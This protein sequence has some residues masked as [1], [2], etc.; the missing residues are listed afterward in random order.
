MTAHSKVEGWHLRLLALVYIRQ[1]TAQETQNN[2]ESTRRQDELAQ[3]ARQMGWPDT[4]VRVVDENLGTSGARSQ[5]RTGFQRLVAS[6]GMG[7]VGIVLAT[8]V[9][10]LYRLSSDWHRV[11]E[12]CAVFQLLVA[13]ED[14]VYDTRNLNDRL[15]MG[16]KGTLSAAELQILRARMHGA[17]LN[18]A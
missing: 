8:E 12:L 15:L 9:S 2:Q 4:A 5:N 17:L 18:K 1:S 13:D 3:R 14:G 7:E 16:V 11:I 10:R 6:I